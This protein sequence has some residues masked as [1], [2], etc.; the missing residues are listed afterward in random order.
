[1]FIKHRQE[2]KELKILRCLQ[3]RME[4]LAKDKQHYMNLEKGYEGE[5]K[6]DELLVGLPN[7]WLILNDLLFERNSTEFQIDSLLF[8]ANTFN[9]F[10]VKN[11][12]GDYFVESEK[13]FSTS[14]IEITSPLSQMK[15]CETLLSN[16]LKELGL[17]YPIKSYLVFINPEFTLYQAP[18]DN[19]IIFPSQLDRFM[20][21]LLTTSSSVTDKQ[22]KTVEKLAAKHLQDSS[23]SRLPKYEYEHLKKGIT[24]VECNSFLIRFN[25]RKLACTSCSCREKV[26][27]A[28]LRS[29]KEYQLLFPERKITTSS[30]HDW[31]E[32]IESKRAIWRIL[33][34]NFKLE[35]HTQRSNYII[36][37]NT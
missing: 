3:A 28:V 11:F 7:D 6:F 19:S 4:L 24:C 17:F 13:W 31:C 9:M 30:I 21:N 26:E 15:R 29:V 1:M 36:E 32:V 5:R 18:Y 10:E 14:G 34:K 12:S 23:F 16:L 33:R 37:E 8:S 35:G 22:M 20:K 2:S 25:E 27:T